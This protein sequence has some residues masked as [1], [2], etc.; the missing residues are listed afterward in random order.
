[1]KNSNLQDEITVILVLYKES[2]DLIS[3][4]LYSLKSFKKIIIDND[5]NID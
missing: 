1:M 3:K 4:T 2:F 5:N